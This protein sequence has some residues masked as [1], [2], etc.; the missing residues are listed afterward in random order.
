MPTIKD[1]AKLAGVSTATV[2]RVINNSDKVSEAA[3]SA[4]L[5]AMQEL[6]YY[7]NTIARSLKTEATMSIGIVIQDLSNTILASFCNSIEN[8]VSQ[9]GYL[10]LIASSNNCPEMEEKYLRHMV[11]RHIDALVI[12][13]C[14][15]NNEFIARISQTIPT[16]A[17]YRRLDNEDYKGD[18]I[19][20]ENGATMFALTQYLLENGHRKIFIIN[21]PQDISS[22]Y[23]RYRGFCKAMQQSGILVD[24]EYPYQYISDYTRQGGIDGCR[25]MLEMKDRATALI[26][27]NAEVLIGALIYLSKQQIKIPDDISVVSYSLPVNLPLFPIDITS[28]TQNPSILGEKAAGLLL[29]RVRSS[30]M[31]N[32]EVIYPCLIHYGNSVRRI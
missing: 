14:G 18:Y 11:Q 22:G 6:Q 32:R 29:E 28:A 27:T 10:S 19:D 9:R 2:S 7:P 23:E 31:Q 1:I 8:C 17:A 20:D 5:E 12:Q 16:V 24:D 21:G 26:A 30:K 4:V 13:S 25:K 15:K 3:R